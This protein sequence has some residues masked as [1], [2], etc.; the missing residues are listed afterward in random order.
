MRL[1][2]RI[3]LALTIA[4]FMLGLVVFLQSNARGKVIPTIDYI[5]WVIAFLIL[6][7]ITAWSWRRGKKK[8]S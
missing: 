4:V 3:P 6:A 5:I 2:L 8:S 1:S 7:G